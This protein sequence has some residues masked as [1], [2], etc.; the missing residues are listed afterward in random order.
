MVDADIPE[1]L[2][3]LHDRRTTVRLSTREQAYSGIVKKLR[4][5]LP[6]VAL[7]I[8]LILMVW[9][10]IQIELENLRFKAAP[11]DKKIL[12]QAATEN[13]LLNADFST[14]DSKGR[15]FHILADQAIQM[16]SDP[17]KVQMVNPNGTLKISDT[18]TMTLRGDTGSFLQDKQFLTL[19]NH[20]V[21]TRSDGTVMKTE[22]LHMD[23]AGNNAQTDQPVTIDSPQGQLWAR[24]MT[25]KDA[26]RYT[27]FTGPAKLIINTDTPKKKA[28]T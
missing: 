18:E 23:L 20:V 27:V 4:W 7:G 9:P 19:N 11:I 25:T 22:L 24:G 13:R 10:R 28:G 21:M 17:D 1:R 16:N 26:G 8:L 2:G 14:V 12:E 15:P 3:A 5:A 6:V